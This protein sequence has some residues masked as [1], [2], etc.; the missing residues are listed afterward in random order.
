MIIRFGF[1]M[2]KCTFSVLAWKA[3]TIC[4][5]GE[6]LSGSAGT[7]AERS[8]SCT[9]GVEEILLIADGTTRPPRSQGRTDTR[10][11]LR[12]R[13][14]KVKLDRPPLRKRV[15]K[16]LGTP[17]FW[18]HARAYLRA[19]WLWAAIAVL[20]L[21]IGIWPGA[22][23]AGCFAY[24]FYHTAPHSHPAVYPLKP[25]LAVNSDEF[26]ITMAGMTGMPLVSGNAVEI[27]NDGDEFYPAMLNAIEDA[28]HSVTMEQ[29]V[30]WNGLVGLRFAQAFAEKSQKGVPVKLLVDAVGS[31]SL[32]DEIMECLRTSGSQLS[33]FR[34][35]HWYTP[36]RANQRTHRKSLIIDGRVA[37]TGGAGIGDQWLGIAGQEEGWR[38]VQ[39][40][41]EG[42]AVLAQQAGFAQ[43]WLLMTGELLSGRDFFPV[44]RPAGN[45]EVQTI[46]SS[47]I[48]GAGAVGTMYMIAVQCAREYLY[49]AN[50]YFIPDSRV[51]AM[52][53]N[54][55]RRGVTVKLMIAGEHND[56]WW[57]RQNSVRIYGRL[58]EAGVEIYEFVP[59]MLHQKIM[60]VDGA[61]AT[62]G[63]TNFDNRSFA[64]N[65][66]TNVCFWQ[67]YLIE[68]LRRAF[69]EDLSRCRRIDLAEWRR[70]SVWQQARERFAS[71]IEDQV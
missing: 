70:R 46:L 58:L 7:V 24:L 48:S 34:P 56:S 1:V 22:F 68:Q 36:D 44:P 28:R 5:S 45:I 57:A 37:F 8:Q 71:L 39:V 62:V 50:P 33:W 60:V 55:R 6:F 65:E 40:R 26:R 13:A 43:N 51:I 64:L 66:E 35:I 59:T 30:F 67:P 25:G 38:D 20:L 11:W 41:V 27:Y 54:A 10:P 49:I 17:E 3:C 4:P 23:V 61:W 47:P 12:A 18:D 2:P 9:I 63:T 14:G 29:H 19:S 16:R 52:L 32:G 69:L 15:R 21:E 42:P 53:R 31:A